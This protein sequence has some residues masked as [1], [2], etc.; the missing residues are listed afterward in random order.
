M[1]LS[2]KS[3]TIFLLW[4]IVMGSLTSLGAENVAGSS[5]EK[6]GSKKSHDS[7]EL[8]ETKVLEVSLSELEGK[9]YFM[10]REYESEI[11]G[12]NYDELRVKTL[13][14]LPM[15]KVSSFSCEGK[16]CAETLMNMVF[17][18]LI[19]PESAKAGQCF[20]IRFCSKKITFTL[21]KFEFI[22]LD[23]TQ[24]ILVPYEQDYLENELNRVERV[25][26][27]P[28]G[29]TIEEF[30][31]FDSFRDLAHQ[32]VTTDDENSN[33]YCNKFFT[34][35]GDEKDRKNYEEDVCDNFEEVMKYRK[36]YK[37]AI[38]LKVRVP[39]DKAHLSE[40]DGMIKDRFLCLFSEDFPELTGKRLRYSK[41]KLQIGKKSTS[42][43][44]LSPVEE[45]EEE[46]NSSCTLM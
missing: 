14:K 10:T 9:H 24:V 11:K 20:Q 27:S 8:L 1:I 34:T 30:I 23:G 26:K 4:A 25:M 44:V 16:L 32:E 39:R 21:S 46:S 28:G 31:P 5:C 33:G 18:P 3:R 6:A 42:Y 35:A 29:E 13:P 15:A 41:E 17:I 12:L 19:L 45:A 37:D 40:G 38:L 43:Y 7:S 2:Q 22:A 36:R